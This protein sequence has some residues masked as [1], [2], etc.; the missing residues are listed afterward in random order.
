MSNL[1]PQFWDNDTLKV[2][3]TW[4]GNCENILECN[5]DFGKVH[6]A[7]YIY[8]FQDLSSIKLF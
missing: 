8:D 6:L 3:T 1:E 5:I 2:Y 7:I 4:N